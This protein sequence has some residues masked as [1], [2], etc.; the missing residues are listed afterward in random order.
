MPNCV[1]VS[2]SIQV[3]SL[4]VTLVIVQVPAGAASP[5]P[6]FKLSGEVGSVLVDGRIK[7]QV[8]VLLTVTVPGVPPTPH[9]TVR[10]GMSV[11]VK[12]EDEKFIAAGEVDST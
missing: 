4:V 5:I 2:T 7:V 3:T 6:S 9:V 8:V 11:V 1:P 12:G 10:P